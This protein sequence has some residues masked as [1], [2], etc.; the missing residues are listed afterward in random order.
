MLSLP[1]NVLALLEEGRLSV[2]YMLRFELDGGAEG[3]WNDSYS[4]IHEGVTFLPM[5]GNLIVDA[6]PGNSDLSSD[7]VSVTISGLDPNVADILEN[8]TWHQRA[9]TV[10]RAFLDDNGMVL[11]ARAVFSGFLDEVRLTD[12]E[13]DMVAAILSIESNNRELNRSTGRMR[14]D[15]DQRAHGGASDGFFKH[16][17]NAAID[18]DIYWGRKGPSSPVR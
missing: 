2:R 10:Y 7:A 4:V 1:S 12:A 16:A 13:G 14:S 15:N 5:G 8:E 18:T 6:I 17:T 3:L 9:V 11:D